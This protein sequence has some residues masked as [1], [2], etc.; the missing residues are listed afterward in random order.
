[1]ARSSQKH[2]LPPGYERARDVAK[3][4]ERAQ[5]EPGV[6]A[7]FNGVYPLS[8]LNG[9]F[10]DHRVHHQRH[11]GLHRIP[12]QE[13]WSCIDT[14]TDAEAALAAIVFASDNV[15]VTSNCGCLKCS[16]KEWNPLLQ[17][18]E[19]LTQP[20]SRREVHVIS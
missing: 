15:S 11:Q 18:E 20:I 13:I 2:Q 7:W 1:M 8:K 9:P 16:D 5:A 4:A 14:T 6:V 10:K 12:H 19:Y 3:R 17:Y